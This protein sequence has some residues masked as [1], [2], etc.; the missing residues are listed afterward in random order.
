MP[1]T[2]A[3]ERLTRR[4]ELGKRVVKGDRAYVCC[5][6]AATRLN[7]DITTVIGSFISALLAAPDAGPGLALALV[8]PA[9]VAPVSG[10]GIGRVVLV[11]ESTISGVASASGLGLIVLL[12][13][14][15]LAAIAAQTAALEAAVGL[16]QAIGQAVATRL[17]DP[18]YD[19]LRKNVL[20]QSAPRLTIVKKIRKRL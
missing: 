19:C 1:P 10:V 15:A 2:T 13:S 7:L 9:A 8:P 11:A 18:C 20:S 4:E 5:E 17:G 6:S 16:A 12:G 14:S 3:I